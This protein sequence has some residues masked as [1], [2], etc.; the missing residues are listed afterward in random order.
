MRVLEI[1]SRLMWLER[2]FQEMVERDIKPEG[3]K[4]LACG[5]PP[6]CGRT[7]GVFGS[8]RESLKIHE[9]KDKWEV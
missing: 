6:I 2:G 7:F 1:A 3:R 4:R 5:S 8:H 9:V